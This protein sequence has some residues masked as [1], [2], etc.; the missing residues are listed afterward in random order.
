MTSSLEHRL[1]RLR[2]SSNVRRA[3]AQRALAQAGT[4]MTG[5]YSDSLLRF[6]AWGFGFIDEC[7]PAPIAHASASP[8]HTH[9]PAR[10]SAESFAFLL[11]WYLRALVNALL[12]PVFVA[13]RDAEREGRAR[14]AEVL[15]LRFLTL[16]NRADCYPFCVQ[17][18]PSGLWIM[19]REEADTYQED[20]YAA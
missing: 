9:V 2:A 4:P 12:R 10:L 20:D 14:R 1:R 16:L 19:T 3:G 11:R 8:R 15:H 5:D 17:V 13:W 6:A 18:D 7:S